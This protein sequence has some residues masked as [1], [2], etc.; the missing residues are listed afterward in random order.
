MGNL[1]FNGVSTVDLGLVI[2][3]PP[4]YDFPEKDCDIYHIQGKNGDIIIDNDSYKNIKRQYY[5]ALAFRP[6]T[7]FIQNAKSIVDW[8]KKPIGYA[9]LQDS[10]EPDF[11][12]LA[13][14]KDSGSLVN[15][16]DQATSITV[17]FDCKPQKYLIDGDNI[18]T[19]STQNTWLELPNNTSFNSLPELTFSGSGL[20]ITI[21]NGNS[22][23]NPDETYTIIVANNCS[24]GIINS[25][26][27]D[28]YNNSTYINDKITLSNGFPKLKPGKNWIKFVGT[29]S[30]NIKPRWWT[31]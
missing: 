30:V 14:F 31:L 1:I 24:Y 20:V 22:Y 10:Y 17:E 4:T 21:V 8:L 13:M 12:R 28:C 15:I 6:G 11:Y 2:Q 9:K 5:L 18:K 7:N 29:G 3:A 23:S 27:Q 19:L 26:L 25:E 16:Y